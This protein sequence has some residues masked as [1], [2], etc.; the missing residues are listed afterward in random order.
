MG[1]CNYEL[2]RFYTRKTDVVCIKNS[3]IPK[4]PPAFQPYQAYDADEAGLLKFI[5]ELF[6][7]GALTDGEVLNADVEKISSDAGTLANDVARELASKFAAA[8]VDEQLYQTASRHL[9]QVRANT[10]SSIPENSM[11]EGNDNGINLLGFHYMP[12]HA[13]GRRPQ[14]P[15]HFGGY[16][17]WS[18]SRRF[19][20]DI[21]AIAATA[22]TISLL[23]GRLHP[24][25]LL[26]GDC[27]PRAASDIRHLRAGGSGSPRFRC[28]K[29]PRCRRRCRRK[30]EVSRSNS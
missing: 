15:C 23:V 22:L 26:G 25:L 29:A 2:G 17:P 20:Y 12:G 30:S 21:G 9:G 19:L 13:V 8:R 4:P 18:S 1:W 27:R 10:A 6:V 5:N 24:P 11:I 28:S 14:C 16:G 3:D 7:T